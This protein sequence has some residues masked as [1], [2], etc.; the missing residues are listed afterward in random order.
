M[1]L[2]LLVVLQEPVV[3]DKKE[4]R[5][6]VRN[7]ISSFLLENGFSVDV[8]V[9]KVIEDFLLPSVI[10]IFY[11]RRKRSFCDYLKKLDFFDDEFKILTNRVIDFVSHFENSKIGEGKKDIIL[12]GDVHPGKVTKCYKQNYVYYKDYPDYDFLLRDILKTFLSD[13]DM[14]LPKIERMSNNWFKREYFDGNKYSNDEKEVEKYYFNLGRFLPILLLIRAI[15][16]NAENILIEMPY[17]KFFDMETILC[18]QLEDG[19][20][21]YG[22]RN[23][24][25]IKV[26]DDDV[27]LL[28]GGLSN[29]RSLLKPVLQGDLDKPYIVWRVRSSAVYNNIPFLNG[30]RVNPDDYLLQIENG[31]KESLE[32]VLNVIQRKKIILPDGV[33]RVIL[34]PTRIYRYILLKSCYPQIYN[35]KGVEEFLR[36]ELKENGLIHKLNSSQLLDEEVEGMMKLL[37][38]VFYSSIYSREIF[39]PSGNVIGNLYI[40]PYE[41]WNNYIKK[42]LRREYFDKQMKIIKDSIVQFN[43]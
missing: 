15:D 21:S 30:E 10:Y 28:S 2:P 19:F 17:P 1:E 31:Y 23:T 41:V 35:G 24:G 5:Q 25:A 13:Y 43:I 36:S 8:S 14:F 11:K 3:K 22:I 16:I 42:V 40:S 7:K 39:S 12:L 37:V 34:R 38:P 20:D 26:D 27:S 32:R 29:N 18:P 4:I 6:L 33:I 9:I